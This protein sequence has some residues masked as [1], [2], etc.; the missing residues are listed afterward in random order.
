MRVAA[1]IV[2]RF[3]LAWRYEM[4][5][6]KVKH[7]IARKMANKRRIAIFDW[8]SDS[9]DMRVAGARAIRIVCRLRG[10]RVSMRDALWG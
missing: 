10:E 9:W 8:C 3:T 4:D 2:G 5:F 7:R 6:D 1:C